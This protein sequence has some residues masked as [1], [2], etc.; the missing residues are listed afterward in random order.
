MRTHYFK[1]NILLAIFLVLAV[2]LNAQKTTSQYSSSQKNG[3]ERIV[4]DRDDKTYQLEFTD[5][6]MTFL[7]VDGVS[8]PE[9]KWGDYK[10]IIDE[11]REQMKK[12]KEQARLDRIQADKD[13]EQAKLDRIQADRDRLQAQK[14]REQAQLDRIRADKDRGQS[15]HDRLQAQKDRTQAELDRQQSIKDKQQA[16]RD[17]EQAERDREQAVRDRAQAEK[18]REQAVRDRAQAEKDRAQAEADRKLLADLTVDLVNDKLITDASDLRMLTMSPVEMTVNG[19]KQPDAV[20][21]KYQD[22]YSRFAK[23]NFSYMSDG[24]GKRIQMHRDN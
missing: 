21:K 15:D 3:K 18:D 9:E 16:D 11:I 23:G 12:D 2:S 4:T 7:S 1:S 10:T 6:K 14:D 22:K 17:R 8:V 13:R 20:H 24:S 5:G 19:I